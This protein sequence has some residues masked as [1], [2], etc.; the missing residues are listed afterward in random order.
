MQI[1]DQNTSANFSLPSSFF[2]SQSLV[3]VP[4]QSLVSVEH[5]PVKV[6]RRRCRL[7][8]ATDGML[9]GY[10]HVEFITSEAA[11]KLL[12]QE[13]KLDL[14]KERGAYT[15]N[16]GRFDNSFQRQGRGGGESTTVFVNGFDKNDIEDKISSALGDHFG[17]SKSFKLTK[18]SI[19]ILAFLS[20]L[21]STAACNVKW[22][23]RN[24]RVLRFGCCTSRV[25]GLE[26]KD[27]FL[28][29]LVQVAVVIT[30]LGIARN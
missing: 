27:S 6:S 28:F 21:D 5:L 13:V 1:S 8:C 18:V 11:A 20:I 12:G 23:V 24:I 7:C 14:A 25:V 9:K 30:C 22:I 15:L 26:L 16:S 2:P 3:A 19:L 10:G 17:C 29:F 4:S